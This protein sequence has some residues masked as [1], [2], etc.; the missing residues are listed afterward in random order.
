MK[1]TAEILEILEEINLYDISKEILMYLLSLPDDW[2]IYKTVTFKHFNDDIAI[3]NLAWKEL[4]DKGYI[5]KK[6][7]KY[8]NKPKQTPEYKYEY[9]YEYFQYKE[10]EEE[11]L[12]STRTGYQLNI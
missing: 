12:Y 11:Y 5:S 2:N 8:E 4:I 10:R 3:L 7:I 1:I 9:E 6:L